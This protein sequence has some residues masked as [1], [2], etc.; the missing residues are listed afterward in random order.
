MPVGSKWQL[1]VPSDLAYG[2]RSP[3][4]EIGPDSTLIFEVELLSIQNKSDEKSP[5][6]TSSV[7]HQGVD[8]GFLALSPETD[9]SRALR[10]SWSSGPWPGTTTVSS[11]RASTFSCSELDD[12]LHRPS[13]QIGAADASRKQR[14]AGNQLLLQRKVEADAALGVS[15]RMNHVRGERA[16]LDRVRLSDAL[17]DLDLARIFHSDPRG[18]HIQHLQQG[19]VVL[20]EQDGRAGGGPQLH[21]S[22]HVIDVSVSDDDLLHLSDCAFG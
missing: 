1:F 22:A 17:I 4:P 21:R 8:A 20:V 19:I 5:D 13:R 3:G 9:C 2:E 14:V 18:L 6:K 15:R 11:G 10:Q 16:R 7:D 12:F